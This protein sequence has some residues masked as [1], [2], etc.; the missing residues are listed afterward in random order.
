M[1]DSDAV[2]AALRESAA[3]RRLRSALREE[4]ASLAAD[5]EDRKEMSIVREQMADLAPPLE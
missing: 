5:R 4:A 3:R 1:N 2:R